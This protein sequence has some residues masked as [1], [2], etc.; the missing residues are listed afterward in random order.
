M[1]I[2]VTIDWVTRYTVHT[3]HGISFSSSSSNGSYGSGVSSSV[4]ISVS[5]RSSNIISISVGGVVVSTQ[6]FGAMLYD[7][8]KQKTIKYIIS[9]L[10][11]TRE[12]M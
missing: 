1:H 8:L 9:V 6:H 5:S 4:G 10:M 3:S 12:S 7:Y 11:Y 2:Y